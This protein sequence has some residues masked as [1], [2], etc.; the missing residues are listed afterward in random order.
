[1]TSSTCTNT[2]TKK[3]WVTFFL[4]ICYIILSPILSLLDMWFM[5]FETLLPWSGP[6]SWSM[7][8]L[9]AGKLRQ[10]VEIVKSEKMVNEAS[11]LVTD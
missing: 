5:R 4:C 10:G 6:E 8:I 1:M 7:Q 3:V 9:K 11:V 2:P